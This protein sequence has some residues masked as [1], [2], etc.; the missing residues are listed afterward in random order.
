MLVPRP[1][2]RVTLPDDAGALARTIHTS[3]TA[4]KRELGSWACLTDGTDN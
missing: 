3:A 4:A 1:I 2:A